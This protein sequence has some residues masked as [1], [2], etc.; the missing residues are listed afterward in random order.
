MAGGA[1]FPEK[2]AGKQPERLVAQDLCAGKTGRRL[3]RCRAET[4]AADGLPDPCTHPGFS[5][6]IHAFHTITD[7][8]LTRGQFPERDTRVTLPTTT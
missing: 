5:R 7:T 3:E 8:E 4:T 2:P 6:N 1:N